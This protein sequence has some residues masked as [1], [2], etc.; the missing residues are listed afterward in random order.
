M[1]RIKTVWS[2]LGALA[3]LTTVST[4]AAHHEGGEKAKINP[5]S[6]DL[7]ELGLV[8]SPTIRAAR[9][10]QK[11][12]NDALIDACWI[13]GARTEIGDWTFVGHRNNN[14][15]KVDFEG[16]CTVGATPSNSFGGR[17]VNTL[18]EQNFGA[19]WEVKDGKTTRTMGQNEFST[20][21]SSC[22]E[23]ENGS[24]LII[25]RGSDDT[26]AYESR[27]VTTPDFTI[28]VNHLR[29]VGTREAFWPFMTRW[30]TRVK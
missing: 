2:V 26:W 5:T 7:D 30:N 10:A 23:L 14:G 3:I 15:T 29:P 19:T 22:E 18:T 6:S 21:V 13:K 16:T 20:T 27:Y 8:V 1:N 12:A 17:C 25:E 28:F 24:F 9:R 4:F 11:K